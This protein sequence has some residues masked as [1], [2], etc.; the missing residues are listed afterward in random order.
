MRAHGGDV[1]LAETGASGTRFRLT[2]PRAAA[3]ED[4]ALSPARLGLRG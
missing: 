3:A 4:A 1:V 2:L